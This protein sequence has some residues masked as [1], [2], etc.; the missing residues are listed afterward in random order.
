MYKAL[1]LSLIVTTWI[2][3]FVPSVIFRLAGIVTVGRQRVPLPVSFRKGLVNEML[4][5][6]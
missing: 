1:P 4:K 2:L 6:G 3:A 5:L